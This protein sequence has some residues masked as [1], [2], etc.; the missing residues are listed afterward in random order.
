MNNARDYCMHVKH[1]PN[2]D[3]RLTTYAP[4]RTHLL[5]PAGSKFASKNKLSH[6][7]YTGTLTVGLI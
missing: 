1:G 7:T 6:C 2:I 4:Y 5:K 3:Q